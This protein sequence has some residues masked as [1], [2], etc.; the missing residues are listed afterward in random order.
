VKIYVITQGSDNTYHSAWW[1]AESAQK[2]VGR[3]NADYYR[4][5]GRMPF[6]WQEDELNA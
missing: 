1:T 2:E 4:K 6:E 5:Y 3:L